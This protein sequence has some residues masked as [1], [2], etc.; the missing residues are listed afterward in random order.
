MKIIIDTDG[1]FD[2]YMALM[3]ALKSD[4]LDVKGITT[5]SGIRNIS[6]ST[7]AVLNA[8]ELI[9]RMEVPVAMGTHS[10]MSQDL[11]STRRRMREIW[12]NG[13]RSDTSEIRKP[14]LEAI[15]EDGVK[16][17]INRVLQEPGEISIITLGALTNVI[18]EI[19]PGS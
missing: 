2:D 6:E 19:S 17:M 18:I 4:V 5:L 16:F 1:E 15:Q 9:D 3:L 13:G 12:K 8:V 7:N 11:T 10:S 14:E